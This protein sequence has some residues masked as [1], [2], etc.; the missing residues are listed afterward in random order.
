MN[1]LPHAGAALENKMIEAIRA[2][3]SEAEQNKQLTQQQLELVYQQQWFNMFVPKRYGGLEMA[4]IPALQLLEA[5]AYA[6]GSLG[7]TVNLNAGANLFAGY[8]KPELAQEIFDNPKACIAGSGAMG[9]TARP[10]DNGYRVEGHWKY[11]SGSTH[12]TAFTANCRITPASNNEEGNYHSFVFL[13]QEVEVQEAWHAYGLQATASHSFEVAERWLG[14]ERSFSLTGPSLYEKG[15][16]YHFPFVPFGELTISLQLTGIATH[17]IEEAHSLLVRKK[18][19]GRT[20]NNTGSTLEDTMARS[21]ATL[22][23]ARAWLYLTA[24]EAWQAS[25]GGSQPSKEILRKVSLSARH[26]AGSAITTASDI[27]T[28]VGMKAVN[29]KST[30]NRC[31]RDLH[32]ASQHTLVSPLGIAGLAMSAKKLMT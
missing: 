7:W 5:L 29:P 10:E 22:E 16:L 14:E 13:P 32:T 19:V 25:E 31:W 1:K 18:N 20:G 24:S 4:L 30:I 26:A 9:G 17:L 2:E 23:A 27:Y 21:E 15:P 6:D 8:M 28:L 11:A 12:A 3:A